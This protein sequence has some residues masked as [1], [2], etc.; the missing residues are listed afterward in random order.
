MEKKRP[1]FNGEGL[2]AVVRARAEQKAAA[3]WCY[4]SPDGRSFFVSARVAL[5]MRARNGGNVFP[6]KVSK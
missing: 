5:A 1:T 2:P 6:P 4:V 3:S